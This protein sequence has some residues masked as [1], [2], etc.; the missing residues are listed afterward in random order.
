[1]DAHDKYIIKIALKT[2]R[3]AGGTGVTA[4]AL[5]EQLD[6]ANGEPLSSED[7]DLA[8][9]FLSSRGWMTHHMEPVWH[10]KRFTLTERGLT[11][12]EAM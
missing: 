7:H 2:L 1:M 9:D 4:K 5:K 8:F 10:T 6:L 11:V 12:L 3:A